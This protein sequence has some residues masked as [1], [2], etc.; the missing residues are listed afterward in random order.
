[1]LLTRIGHKSK[2]IITGDPVQHDRGFEVNGLNDLIRR[3]KY[4]KENKI[5][6]V[7][8]TDED[9]ERHPIIKSV[10]KM[11][12]HKTLPAKDKTIIPEE[13]EE[14][15]QYKKEEFP[16]NIITNIQEDIIKQLEDVHIDT[17]AITD[18]LDSYES[19]IGELELGNDP[20]PYIE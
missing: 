3:M 18:T 20:S 1:M 4:Y 6:M 14:N 11:Y 16:I 12:K 8:F 9:V 17:N 2:M 7:E 19:V 10:L 5:G 15:N 13:M